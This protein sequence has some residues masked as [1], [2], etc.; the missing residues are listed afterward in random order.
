M[1]TDFNIERTGWEWPR[2]TISFGIALNIG[3]RLLRSGKIPVTGFNLGFG[4]GFCIVQFLVGR[5]YRE[6]VAPRG[7]LKFLRLEKL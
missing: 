2:R 7:H 1:I 3:Q 6:R 4:F 5:E